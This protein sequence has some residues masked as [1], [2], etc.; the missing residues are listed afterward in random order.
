MVTLRGALDKAESV[1]SDKE[2]GMDDE[3]NRLTT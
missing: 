1:K 2:M 3:F